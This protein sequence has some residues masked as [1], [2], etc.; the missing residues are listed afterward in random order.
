MRWTATVALVAAAL[1]G[2][3]E[4]GTDSGPEAPGAADD[5]PVDWARPLP[6]SITGLERLA[7]TPNVTDAGGIW[8]EGDLAY[9]AGQGA[10]LLVVDPTTPDAPRVIGQNADVNARDV[11]LL[12]YGN[13][14]VAVAAGSGA[15]M[16]FIDVTVPEEP[17][18]LSSVLGPPNVHN[19]AVVPGTHIVYNSRSV[20]TPGIDV[21]DATDPAAPELV[22]TFGD[23]TCHDV[24]FWMERE[25]AYCPGVRETQIWDISDPK[26]PE[27]VTRIVNPAINIHHW[28]LPMH[29]G[30][31]LA[32]GDEFAGSTDAA[33]GC[34]ANQPN[35]AGGTLSDPVGA[36]WFYD[37][38]DEAIPMPLS[39]VSA[40]LP[41][42]QTPP[43]P[44]TAHFG[45]QVG[46][47]DVLVVGWRAAGTYLI[48][49]S[50]LSAPE[51]LAKV[52]GDGDVWEA[53]YHNGYVFT[54]DLGRGFEVFVPV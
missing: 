39:W 10:G 29:N 47:R 35:P 19:V 26:A 50:D 48:D 43:T 28:A 21:V 17:Q 24:T 52:P 13:R 41:A 20:D 46:D 53:R 12:H 42:D 37:I 14:T 6:E 8:L 44:C 7:S 51:T 9:V 2:C 27:V 32:V 49:F 18:H 25:R 30:S 16:H 31:L 1:A 45:E 4:D 34:F 40:E 36:V 15:G 22:N 3:A 38:S 33:A 54:G 23:L 11:D 5:A